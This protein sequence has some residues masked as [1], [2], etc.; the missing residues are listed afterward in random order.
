MGDDLIPDIPNIINK[1]GLGESPALFLF[2]VKAEDTLWLINFLE[3]T[4]DSEI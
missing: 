1:Q 3:V 2:N 4:E